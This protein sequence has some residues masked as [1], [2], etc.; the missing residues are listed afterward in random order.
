MG[1]SASPSPLPSLSASQP[2]H[3]QPSFPVPTTQ[4]FFPLAAVRATLASLHSCKPQQVRST[5]LAIAHSMS[6]LFVACGSLPAA[7]QS[8]GGAFTG[9]HL[10]PARI[11]ATFGP[12]YSDAHVLVEEATHG[13]LPAVTVGVPTNLPAR[14]AR[15][16]HSSAKQNP[17]AV[18][19]R[20]VADLLHGRVFIVP[21]SHAA[22]IPLLRPAPLGDVFKRNKHRVIHDLSF[23][24]QL[25]DGSPDW[26]VNDLTDPSEVPDCDIGHIFID[27]LSR[28]YQLRLRYRSAHIVLAK[29]DVTDAFR[30]VRLDPRL[31]PMFSY[32]WGGVVVIELFLM[33]G[34]LGAPGHFLRWMKAIGALMQATRPSDMVPAR[35]DQLVLLPSLEIE[36]PPSEPPAPVP[37]DPTYPRQAVAHGDAPFVAPSFMDDTL[38]AEVN[39]EGRPWA[40]SAALEEAHYQLFGWRGADVVKP[41]KRTKWASQQ[42]ILGVMVDAHN[43]T[44][45]LPEDKSQQ[46]HELLYVHFYP[47]RQEASP[48]DI[49]SLVGKLRCYAYCIRPGRYF[50]RRLINVCQHGQALDSPVKLDVEFHRDLDMWREIIEDP[51]LQATNYST[52]LYNHLKRSPEILVIGDAMAEAGGGYVSGMGVE[53]AAWWRVRWPALVV[54][55]FHRTSV[56]TEPRPTMVTMAH[57]ELATLVIG[58]G[59]MTEQATSPSGRAV[60]A[61]A[62]NTNAV[63][64]AKKGG[65]RDGR[66]AALVR[67]LG[68]TEAKDRFSL[69]AKHIP[70]IDNH[71]S[72]FIS[73]HD[74][75]DILTY[76]SNRPPPARATAWRQ[77]DPPSVLVTKVFNILSSTI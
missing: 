44:V 33:F 57:L 69:A 68:V 24:Y 34:W 60:L 15:G 28:V 18:E 45:S 2:R 55:R 56:K 74:E 40:A 53:G 29:V 59:T 19:E 62:D 41:S 65:A 42:E 26:S 6:S 22:M 10:N 11:A 54:E 64:W 71:E 66:A 75:T 37:D 1:T 38:Q 7:L 39:H 20:L 51:A 46:L 16:N 49:M 70:G 52:P 58:V 47:D 8:L 21:V 32:T 67:L 48:R 14:L 5:F 72:D 63:A 30:H 35:T 77:V 3:P 9:S 17:K 50:L 13:L 43:M 36:E 76:L 25:P 12:V 4:P 31:A 27:F 23:R 73:R 61:L